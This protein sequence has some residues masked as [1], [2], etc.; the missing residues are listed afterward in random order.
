MMEKI[1]TAGLSGR[2]RRDEAGQSLVEM[3]LVMGLL[4][5]VLV[6][7]AD[8]GRA[9]HSYIIITNAAREGA[10]Y[11][12]RFPRAEDEGRIKDAVIREAQASD[13]ILDPSHITVYSLPAQPGDPIRIVV[14]YQ[15]PTI[16]S[17]IV[18]RVIGSDHITL[19]AGA[20]MVVFGL[21]E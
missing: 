20:Q 12:S 4:L 10:R 18:S 17:S 9:F 11:A 21:D 7:I 5:L 15:F 1:H 19:R 6:G 3:A 2:I 16:M 13:V 8:F 14:T